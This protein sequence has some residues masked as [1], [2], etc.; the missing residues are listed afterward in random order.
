MATHKVKFIT[1]NSGKVGNSISTT[2]ECRSGEFILSW[3]GKKRVLPAKVGDTF[4]IACFG[5]F[6]HVTRMKSPSHPVARVAWEKGFYSSKKY[7]T[8]T[9]LYEAASKET[10]WSQGR[11]M[12]L[13]SVKIWRSEH[14]AFAYKAVA[15]WQRS[16]PFGWWE[17]GASEEEV[18]S[19]LKEALSS[20]VSEGR[21]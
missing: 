8:L 21:L 7:G 11:G 3:K 5:G 16:V 17:Q 6:P 20:Y 12:N 9:E 18:E 19:L 4:L 1:G 13:P 15:E 2:Y 14:C 10:A